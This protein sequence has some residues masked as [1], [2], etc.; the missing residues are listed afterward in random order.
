M[1]WSPNLLTG[2]AKFV[3]NFDSV[4][5]YKCD[6]SGVHSAEKNVS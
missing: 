5:L 3:K 1:Q 6:S 4:L 2:D